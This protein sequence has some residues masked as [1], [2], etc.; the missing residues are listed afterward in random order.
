MQW[1]NRE[2]CFIETSVKEKEA[3]ERDKEIENQ[4]KKEIEEL[5]KLREMQ[6]EIQRNEVT[7]KTY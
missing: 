1:I 7:T 6:R 2:V 4:K 3:K 5:T